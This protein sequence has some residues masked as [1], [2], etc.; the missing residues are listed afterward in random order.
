MLQIIQ[1]E[2]DEH[3]NHVQEI[4]WEYF[5]ETKLIFSQE[6]G[7]NL[8]VN[9]FSEQYLTQIDQ[10]APSEGRLLLGQ[11]DGQIAG[12]VCLRKIG[13]DIGE[14]KRMYVKPELRRKAIGRYLLQAIINE[15]S[16]IGY[17]HLRLDTGLYAKEALALYRRF[18]FQNIVPYVEK[19]EIPQ[20]YRA[21]WVF[22]EL[23]LKS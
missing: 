10:F 3:K 19:T 20:K 9:T 22:M 23:K 11:Y 15:A 17:T 13:E 14:I 5:N 8:D 16:Q 12:C 1:V 4:F 7:I 2:T 6:F 21:N 18:G